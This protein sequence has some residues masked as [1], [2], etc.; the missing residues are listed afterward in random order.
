MNSNNSFSKSLSAAALTFTLIA[1]LNSVWA[2]ETLEPVIVTA[3]PDTTIEQDPLEGYNRTV[4]SFNEELDDNFL[5]PT[6]EAYH[7]ILPDPVENG[8]SNFFSNLREPFNILNNILQFK[9]DDAVSDTVRFGL[10]TTIGIF[11]LFD[12]A[13]EAGLE[14]HKEDFGQTL[15]VWGVESGPYFVLPIL[16]PSTVRDTAGIATEF[17][18]GNTVEVGNTELFNP[19]GE[20]NS[21]GA[22]NAY[23]ATKTV[24]KRANLL[25]TKEMIDD[26]SFDSYAFMRDAYLQKR[27]SEVRDGD[28]ELM[29]LPADL[30]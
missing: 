12:V 16:G 15:G 10:N 5:K 2:V 21:Q 22:E 6:A 8:I 24:S 14:K 20:L 1:P 19:S 11:G 28:I 18:V 4:F 9:L 29:P 17:W 3:S 30:N 7:D 25:T 26:A 27:E 13:S 23:L